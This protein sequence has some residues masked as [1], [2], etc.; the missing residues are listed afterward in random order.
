MRILWR[1]LAL[2]GLLVLCIPGF[3][4]W[5]P[6]TPHNPWPRWFLAGACGIIGLR[7]RTVGHK[8]RA[9]A[10][11]LPN[12]VTWLD[13]PA[14]GRLT[15]TAF[16]AQD[17]LAAHGWLRWLCSLNDTV[18]IARDRRGTV[19]EQVAAVRLAI[20]ETGALTIFAEGGTGDG[21]TIGPFKSSLL[22]AITPVPPGIV[23]QPVWLDY[24]PD[25]AG[26]AWIGEESGK[27]NY[28]RIAARRDPVVL[29]AHF[30]RPLEGRALADRKTIAIAA[31]ESITAIRD[32]TERG[33]VQ[34][35]AL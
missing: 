28:L 26:I 24:G 22:S 12:H 2:L 25:S 14:L 23:I 17:G 15:G 10:F 9:G 34:R 11:L 18:F 32:L 27:D 30:L 33:R 35:V 31:R 3:L 8:V 16:V 4:I 13:I 1:S 7:V 6:F 19:A 20:R 5:K 29:T 21:Q